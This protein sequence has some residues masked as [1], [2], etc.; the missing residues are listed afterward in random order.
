M[1]PCCHCGVQPARHDYGP[2]VCDPCYSD[3]YDAHCWDC[4]RVVYQ[5]LRCANCGP[6]HAA[7]MQERRR[8]NERNRLRFKRA[9]RSFRIAENNGTRERMRRLRATRAT[10]PADA[11]A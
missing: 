6:K 9:K 2:P 11:H 10:T 3:R 5:K 4:G 1:R 8:L 7:K